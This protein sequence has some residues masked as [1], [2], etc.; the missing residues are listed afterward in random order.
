MRQIVAWVS[1]KW[2]GDDGEWWTSFYLGP[3]FTRIVSHE[4]N[5]TNQN[6]GVEGALQGP[7]QS[8]LYFY[9]SSNKE[10][11]NGVTFDLNDVLLNFE[12]QPSG[13]LKVRLESE[14]GGDIDS[15]N[16]QKGDV[17]AFSPRVELKLGKHINLNL[18][19]S[20]RRMDV[21]RGRLYRENLTETRF[22][23]H[24]NLRTLIRL[25]AQYRHID[26]DP[27]LFPNPVPSVDSSLFLQLL[28][29]YKVNPRTVVFVGYSD[30]HR[31]LQDFDFLRTSRTFFVKL[32]YAWNY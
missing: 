10:F 5:L 23:Y 6:I 16:T 15:F 1:R 9:F 14:W 20:F 21:E 3:G 8:K 18:G 12:I 24:F 19:H 2:W 32:G 13:S 4:G 26:R 31:G 28:G 22:Y 29:S 7:M 11:Y 17:L 30:N 27:S 25:I